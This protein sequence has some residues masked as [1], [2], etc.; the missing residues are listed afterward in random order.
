MVDWKSWR[1]LRTWN[2]ERLVLANYSAGV[3]A[4]VDDANPVRQAAFDGCFDQIG[5]ENRDLH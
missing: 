5:C 4:E 3:I 2:A 1:W